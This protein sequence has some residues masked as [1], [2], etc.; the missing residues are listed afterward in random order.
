VPASEILGTFRLHNKTSYDLFDQW[1]PPNMLGGGLLIGKWKIDSYIAI[2]IWRPKLQF[3]LFFLKKGGCLLPAINLYIW[4]PRKRSD[5]RN[6]SSLISMIVE[7]KLLA[8]KLL[9]WSWHIWDKFSAYLKL[10]RISGRLNE[11][12]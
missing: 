10:C 3:R 2:K 1:P 6:L 5:S 4:Q 8:R 9:F 7:L 11:A 12:L